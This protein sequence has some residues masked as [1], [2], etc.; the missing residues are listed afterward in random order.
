MVAQVAM[1]EML[2]TMF[3]NKILLDVKCDNAKLLN[4]ERTISQLQTFLNLTI[5]Y[6]K[7]GKS[8]PSIYISKR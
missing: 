3:N 7:Q 6:S 1:L 2:A 4:V 5:S 8:M